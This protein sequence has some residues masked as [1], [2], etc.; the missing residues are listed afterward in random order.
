[1][2]QGLAVP[3]QTL[4]SDEMN[5][6]PSAQDDYVQLMINCQSRLYSFILSLVCHAEYA[7]EVLQETN[8]VLWKKCDQFE[9][10]TNFV[11]WAFQIARYQVMAHRQRLGRDR[12]VFDDDALD[13]VAAA[14]EPVAEDK[15]DRLVALAHCMKKLSDDG[16]SLLKQ[17]YGEGTPVKS[18]AAELG[19][20]ANRIAVR[21]HRLR[22]ALMDCILKRRLESETA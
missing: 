6:F 20:T 7:S 2:L 18:I 19:Q 22:A 13:N 10:G 4:I 9:P 15:D 21:L 5:E 1:M 17:R 8:L 16:R 3:D 12:H 14:F 11:A